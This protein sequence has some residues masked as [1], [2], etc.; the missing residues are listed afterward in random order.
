MINTRLLQSQMTLK[1]VSSKVLADAQGW[2]LSTTYRKING[3]VSFTVQEVQVCVDLLELDA[4][5]A[6]AIFFAG[7]LSYKTRCSDK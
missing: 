3:K 4:D 7:H 1:G 5:T 2:S 6:T